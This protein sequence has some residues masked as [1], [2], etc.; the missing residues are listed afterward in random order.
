MGEDSA[1]AGVRVGLFPDAL[2]LTGSDRERL[3]ATLGQV[4]DAGV[5]HLC[6]GDHVS[7]NGGQ[8]FDGIVQ[9]AILAAA[10]P[11]LPVHVAVYLLPLRHPVLVARQLTTLAAVAPGRITFGVGVGGAVAGVGVGVG[12]R[13]GAAPAAK[14]LTSVRLFHRFTLLPWPMYRT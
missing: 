10:H 11:D 8:G 7:F 12:V 6:V 13:R 5:D 4:A 9:S 14:T 3:T 2:R 1:R